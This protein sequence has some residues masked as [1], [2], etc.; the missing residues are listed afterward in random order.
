MTVELKEPEVSLWSLN[1]FLDQWPVHGV[2]GPNVQKISCLALLRH[3]LPKRFAMEATKFFALV[4]PDPPEAD[5]EGRYTTTL[6]TQGL[7]ALEVHA[8]TR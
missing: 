1:D 6:C 8:E 5:S 2:S 7:F 3:L 4:K